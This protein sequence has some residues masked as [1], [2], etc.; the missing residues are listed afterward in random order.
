MSNKI[1]ALALVLG[2]AGSASAVNIAIN[3]QSAGTFTSGA[4]FSTAPFTVTAPTPTFNGSTSGAVESNL[5]YTTDAAGAGSGSFT[6]VTSGIA[7][8][9]SGTSTVNFT[10]AG[11][12]ESFFGPYGSM[13]SSTF[14]ISSI[15]GALAG[16]TLYT[17]TNTSNVISDTLD[18]SAPRTD[19]TTG[20][21][22]YDSNSTLRLTIAT[23][24]PEPASMAALAI[25]GL[26][27]L[28]RRRK[29]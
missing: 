3:T 2:V 29:A 21:V 14:A 25:G 1:F 7:G 5:V 19:P 9:P 24:V 8:A 16:S 6:I 20:L 11:S 28:R 18:A 4:T 12:G 17:A 23:P 13:S 15:T 26:G 22:T 10:F 27:L